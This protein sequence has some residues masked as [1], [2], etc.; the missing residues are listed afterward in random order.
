MQSRTKIFFILCFLVVFL[1]YGR[2]I[3]GDFVF[4]DRGIID[5]RYILEDLSRPQKIILLPYFTEE[6]GAYRPIALLSYSLNF[7]LFSG[8]AWSFHLVNLIFY[9]W[10]GI[11]I[12][13]LVKKIFK[14]QLLAEAAALLFLTV[15]IHAEVV[16]NIV[17]RAEIFAL[18]FS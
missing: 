6:A 2:T 13:F 1:I 9:A 14:K 4:D 10:T 12:F 11:L 8:A 3:F 5:H 15:P 7:I 18:F 16:A 17:G